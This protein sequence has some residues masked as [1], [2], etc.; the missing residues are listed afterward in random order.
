MVE[1]TTKKPSK[2]FT[3]WDDFIQRELPLEKKRNL[4]KLSTKLFFLDP[5]QLR[6]E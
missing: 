3:N 5:K 4:L 1:K 6:R 2:P